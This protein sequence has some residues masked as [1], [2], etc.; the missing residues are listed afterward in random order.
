MKK[1][2]LGLLGVTILTGCGAQASVKLDLT[3][4]EKDLGVITTGK[5]NM[6]GL[7][8]TEL[9]YKSELE[10]IYNLKD[11]FNVDE[12]LIESYNVQY[13]KE[14]KELLAVIKPNEGKTEDIKTQMKEFTDTLDNVSMEEYQGYLIYVS[15][16]DNASVMTKVKANENRLFNNMMKLEEYENTLGIKANQVEEILVKIP[17]MITTSS[18]Y[19][20][21]KPVKGEEDNVKKALDEY[22]VNLEKNWATY[23]P[24]QYE[25]V[26]NRKVETIGDYLVYIVSENNDLVFEAIK[27]NGF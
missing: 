19:I 7:I 11:E 27:N 6:F 1:L 23:L 16:S 3:K 8:P 13:N 18:T 9:G 20:I 26:K 15:T 14:E 17:Q 2:L 25:L 10:L 24:D 21:V 12:T 5:F 4:V 22:M